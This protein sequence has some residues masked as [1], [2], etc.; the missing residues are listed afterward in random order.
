M[1]G[2]VLHG[3]SPDVYRCE[4]IAAVGAGGAEVFVH[5]ED[6]SA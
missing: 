4:G 6:R 1:S 2:Q 3:W 5:V